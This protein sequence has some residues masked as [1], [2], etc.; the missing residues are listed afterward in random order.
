M[1][2]KE[3]GEGEER[4]EEMLGRNEHL[5]IHPF[6]PRPWREGRRAAAYTELRNARKHTHDGTSDILDAT[7]AAFRETDAH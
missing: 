3:K 5:S 2:R 4:R 6:I 7:A 1:G